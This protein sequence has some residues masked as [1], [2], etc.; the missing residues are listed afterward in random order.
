MPDLSRS[1]FSHLA[2]T[3][4]QWSEKCFSTHHRG[5]D[6]YGAAGIWFGYFE[7][8]PGICKAMPAICQLCKAQRQLSAFFSL[9]QPHSVCAATCC[10]MLRHAATSPQDRKPTSSTFVDGCGFTIWCR[11]TGCFQHQRR[12]RRDSR[13]KRLVGSQ[14]RKDS[15]ICQIS[16]E[17]VKQQPEDLIQP[18]L[19]L[20]FPHSPSL[21]TYVQ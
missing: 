1:G 19:L 5:C 12:R 15:Q 9:F 3:T 4:S 8:V 10:D 16:Q 14:H 11:C 20:F 21:A 18:I 6:A 13:T 17:R 7:R 2:F